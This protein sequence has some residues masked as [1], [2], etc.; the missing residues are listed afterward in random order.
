MAI[1]S[2]LAF[3]VDPICSILTT[4]IS[5]IRFYSLSSA[6]DL[7]PETQNNSCF[8]KLEFSQDIQIVL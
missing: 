5:L 8:Q 3:E 6:F 2:R 1:L 7:Q 4:L